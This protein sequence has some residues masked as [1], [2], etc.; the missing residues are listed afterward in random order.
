M[1]KTPKT[2]GN[3]CFFIHKQPVNFA[4]LFN[5][6][7]EKKFSKKFSTENSSTFH[8]ALWINYR[9]E[10][11]FAVISRML[12]CRAVSPICNAFSIFSTE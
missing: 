5:K 2:C 12:F 3:R 4:E 11:M 10:L 6:R 9:Q 1:G 7:C 8:N